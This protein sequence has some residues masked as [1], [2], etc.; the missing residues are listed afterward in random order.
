MHKLQSLSDHFWED[1]PQGIVDETIILL[2]FF[3]LLSNYYSDE[4][5]LVPNHNINTY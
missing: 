2:S 5:F 4:C 1:K 3:Y